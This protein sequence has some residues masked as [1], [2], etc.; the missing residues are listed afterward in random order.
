MSL[1][2]CEVDIKSQLNTNLVIME[3]VRPTS[4]V[5][6]AA[7]DAAPKSQDEEF[8]STTTVSGGRKKRSAPK[9]EGDEKKEE[10]FKQPIGVALNSEENKF[11][12]EQMEQDDDRME[13]YSDPENM[14]SMSKPW[15]VG[16]YGI[17]QLSDSHFCDSGYRWSRNVCHKNCSGETK[18]KSYFDSFSKRKDNLH[19]LRIVVFLFSSLY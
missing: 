4:V 16:H 19:I 3:G 6:P 12:E 14:E 11:N 10:D 5:L 8:D 15:S 18:D 1:V 17:F 7:A 13:G 9:D 2:S